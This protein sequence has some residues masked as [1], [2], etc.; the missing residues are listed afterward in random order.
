MKILVSGV[1]ARGGFVRDWTISMLIAY[2]ICHSVFHHYCLTLT[3]V[4]P[5]MYMRSLIPEF[6]ASSGR[7]HS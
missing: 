5:I 1:V 3:A 2:A 7:S 6:L 4:Y